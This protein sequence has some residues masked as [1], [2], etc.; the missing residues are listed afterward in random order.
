MKT[1]LRYT[2]IA[3]LAAVGLGLA[4]C[5]GGGGGNL[6]N[7]IRDLKSQLADAQS[8]RDA[9]VARATAAEAAKAAAD[10]AQATAEAAQAA[11]EMAQADAEAAQAAAE[12]AQAAAET[13]R[14]AAVAARMA[15]EADKMAAEAA[16][17]QAEAA[18][19]AAEAAQMQAEAAQMAAEAAQATAEAERDTA[20]AARDVSEQARKDAEA[21]RTA[22]EAAR[23]AAEAAKATA[24]AERDGA[25][26]A[27]TAA[28]AAQA[29][30][31]AAQAAAESAQADAEAAQA[32]AEADAAAARSAQ[33][34]AEAAQAAAEAAQATAEANLATAQAELTTA[35]NE[36]TRLTGELGTAGGDLASVR[37]MLAAAQADVER[38]TNMI[39]GD[40]T[41]ANP[42]LRAQ[43][44]TVQE[45]LRKLREDAAKM[46]SAT[47][48]TERIARELA[49]RRSITLD[50]VGGDNRVGTA[51]KAL[52]DATSDATAVVAT[53][54]A[55]GKMTVDVNGATTTDE[56][57]GGETTAGSGDWNAFTLTKT[58][59]A[60]EAQDTLV[61]YTDIEAPRDVLF[62]SAAGYAGVTN[63][64]G[65]TSDATTAPVGKAASSYFP[66]NPSVTWTYTGNAGERPKQ[67]RGT[68]DSVPGVFLCGATGDCTL[69]TDGEGKLTASPSGQD[70]T[71]TPDAPNTATVKDPDEA[72]AYFGWWL[73][74]PKANTADHDVE[75]F[76]GGTTGHEA[77]PAATLEGN[78]SYSGTA[79]GKYVTR[80]FTAGVHADSGVGHFTATANLTAKFGNATDAGTI[81]GSISGFVL[82]DANSVGWRVVLGDA[83]AAAAAF[84][85]T[86]QVDFGGGVTETTGGVGTWQGSFYA[87]DTT[88]ALARQYPGT[89]AGTFDAV[90]EN[91][92]VIGGFGA[93]KQ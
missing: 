90:T 55:A 28:E 45:E 47:A 7:E 85:G 72:Y 25:N 33:A 77:T 19:A 8:A 68:Y 10:A 50:T 30:A 3:G 59:G 13:E 91:A 26:A 62:T 52:P 46:A 69:T 14:D 24:E 65:A 43:L 56:Y 49:I 87:A 35:Q 17:M 48:R 36:V 44:A 54:D 74:K 51:A 22:A 34:D 88:S 42:G 93:T 89:V 75:V 39:D 57:A 18:Q 12:A 70:W 82:D 63:F 5:G 6:S 61:I 37:T 83:S 79:A 80:S 2:L 38:L 76:A 84:N 11:A 29:D 86:T 66:S 16:Q 9:A 81:G 64:L 20:N 40:G 23:V 73:N 78:A 71:F 15:A 53:R 58:D 31:E 67:F 32:A 1:R 41:D 4:G 21:A 27:K 92:S 60:T